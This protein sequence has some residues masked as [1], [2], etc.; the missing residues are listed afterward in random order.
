MFEELREELQPAA[1]RAGVCLSLDA[2]P[3][4]AAASATAVRAIVANLVENGIKYMRDDGPRTVTA[5]AR[6][7]G[8][9]VRIEV[10]DTGIGIPAARLPTIFDP[11]VRSRVRRD[12]Y[13]LGL[14]TVKRLADAHGGRVTVVSEEGA[15]TAFVVELPRAP[16][17][18]A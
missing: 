14:A 13:G 11:F 16:E 18:E 15:G 7:Q 4:R 10:R 12:S 9:E 2:E 8:R 1:E 17:V 6:R 5:S 3:V